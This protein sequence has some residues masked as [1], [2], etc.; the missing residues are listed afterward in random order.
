[1]TFGGSVC[2]VAD[3]S[4]GKKPLSETAPLLP[5]PLGCN[6]TP[7]EPRRTAIAVS[8]CADASDTLAR[9]WQAAAAARCGNRDLQWRN[10]G[11]GDSD[12]RTCFPVGCDLSGR[13]NS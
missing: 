9:L 11:A 5:D 12:W 1:M 7:V 10:Y 8:S 4:P 2:Q 3:H 13:A 6:S